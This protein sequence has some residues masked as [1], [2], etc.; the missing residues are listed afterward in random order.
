M[1][2]KAKQ[3]I[4]NATFELLE[5]KDMNSIS[6]REIAAKAGV[7]V[8]TISYYFGGKAQLFSYLM[9][10]YWKDLIELCENFLEKETIT[11]EDA[12]TFC[13]S[14]LLKEMDSTGIIRSEQS[15]YHNYSI[16]DKTKER[17]FLQFKAFRRLIV[18][19]YNG[20]GDETV[21]L[22]KVIAMI[23]ALSEPAFWSDMAA[24]LV[25][26][27]D[28]FIDVYIEQLLFQI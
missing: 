15:M 16:D 6:V 22:A 24:Q 13:K 10:V 28:S 23:S 11:K 25:G 19:F 17:L 8:A 2:E 14:F 3:F 12:F 21:I 4:I 26:D 9:E 5:K 27:I 1:E 18:S 7:N 20:S